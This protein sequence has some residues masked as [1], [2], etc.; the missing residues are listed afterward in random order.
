M[1]KVT[2]GLV[3]GMT[4]LCA[5]QAF[6]A[7]A[8]PREDSQIERGHKVYQKWCYPCH[9]PGADK[10]GTA[11]LAARGQKPAVLEERTDLTPPAIKTFVR[12]GTLFMPTFR[13]T[14]ISDADLD[15]IAAYLTKNNKQ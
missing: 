11:S 12:H 10:P 8:P 9:G 5:A 3:V 2:G 14:E 6:A 13:K 7:P 1:K 15:A 4:L